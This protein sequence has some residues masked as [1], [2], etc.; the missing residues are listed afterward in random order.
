MGLAIYL[1]AGRWFCVCL[2]L[3]GL[4]LWPFRFVVV[5]CFVAVV[6]VCDLIERWMVGF[7]LI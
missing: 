6:L 2:C 1:A 4:G 3:V 5:L 7:D